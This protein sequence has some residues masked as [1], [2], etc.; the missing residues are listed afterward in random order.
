VIPIAKP[1]I[2]EEEKKAVMAVLD[3]GMLAQGPRV[4]E[5]EEKW[6]EFVGTRHAVATSSGTTALQIALSC[7]GLKQGDEVITTPYTFFASASSIL[8]T[9]ARPVFVD[10]DPETYNLDPAQLESVISLQTKAIVPVHLYGLP[11][12]MGP[13]NEVAKAHDLM[14]LEDACQSHGAEYRGKRAGA[15]ALAGCFSFYPTKNM[16]AGEGGMI[17]T[18]DE[19]L[20]SASRLMRDHGMSAKY[21]H[22]SLGYNYR[23]MDLCAA[24]GLEQLKKLEGFNAKRIEN[25]HYLNEKLA[26]VEGIVTPSTP[27]GV[28]HVFHQYA[29]LVK[30]GYPL[31]R[32]GLLEHLRAE[33]VGAGLG[34]PVPV[35]QQEVFRELGYDTIQCPVVEDVVSRTILLP[36]HPALSKEDLDAIVGAIEKGAE[37][38]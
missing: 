24:I 31:E 38:G 33:G 25:A 17:T 34:Y 6:A 20:A 35:Y 8:Y 28:K 19:E 32:D 30:S 26:G 18:D 15:L 4:K 3:S 36:V 2:G 29:I 14:V 27:D 9:S 10:I 12:D 21:R 13:I 37:K 1:L 22:T 23:M 16:I 7:M 5:F 11:S